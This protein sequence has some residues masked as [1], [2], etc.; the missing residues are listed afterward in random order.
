M[1][2]DHSNNRPNLN[3][4][5]NHNLLNNSISKCIT[6]I[7]IVI[8]FLS[9]SNHEAVS[10][11][12]QTPQHNFPI[13]GISMVA[14]V[15]ELQKQDLKPLTNVY[16]NSIAVMPYAFCSPENPVIQYNH[17]GQW[18]GESDAGVIGS[19]SLAHENGFTV[20]LKPHLWIAH[21]EYTGNFKLGSNSEWV[22]WEKSY[23]DY[24]MH[25]AYLADSMKAE[26]FCFAT[27]M[28]TA[29]KE[30]PAF[31]SALIDSVK[32]VYHGKITYAA[33]WDDYKYFS[34]WSKMDYI[35]IDAYFPLSTNKTPS[36]NDYKNGWKKFSGDLKKLSD[37][38]E[39]KI[40]FTEYGYRNVD[41]AA[42]EPWK[43]NEGNKNDAA[44]SNGIQ[45][46][47]ETFATEKWF[48]GGYLWKWYID[49]PRHHNK[50]E[51]DF[52]P[53]GRSAEEVIKNWYQ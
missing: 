50:Q 6:Q 20:M 5:L 41:Y 34:Y 21:G 10:V 44:Q 40:L 52:T 30:R 19:I 4:L 38:S 8:L 51:I 1:R 12:G 7:S 36:V 45:A 9:C 47:F 23:T 42:A 11:Y 2:K 16:A 33:N 13:K 17:S 43:E 18:W 24:V 53:Q 46:L 37:K 3:L 22:I 15:N 48:A 26:I 31:W 25:F 39:K 29:I 27:E 49:K 35:G 32:K 28:G 14:P